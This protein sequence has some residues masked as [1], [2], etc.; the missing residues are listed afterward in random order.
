MKPSSETTM[1]DRIRRLLMGEPAVP[2]YPDLDE[3][4]RLIDHK[5]ARAFGQTPDAIRAEARRRALRI[6][7]ESMRRHR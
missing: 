3:R 6:E 1:F 4:E 5:L 7:V 2:H